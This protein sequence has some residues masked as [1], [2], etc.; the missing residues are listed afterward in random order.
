MRVDV[1]LFTEIAMG[2]FRRVVSCLKSN[3]GWI[4][5]N[6]GPPPTGVPLILGSTWGIVCPCELVEAG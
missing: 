6:D 3:D 5:L 2:L 1:Q 4:D